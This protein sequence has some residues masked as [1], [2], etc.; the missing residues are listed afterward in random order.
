VGLELDEKNVQVSAVE[1]PLERFGAALIADLESSQSAFEGGKIDKIA[2]REPFRPTPL[3][4]Q[5]AKLYFGRVR[6][7]CP[8]PL[9]FGQVYFKLLRFSPS[10]PAGLRVNPP[11]RNTS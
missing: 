4:P 7:G 11:E 10:N 1:D 8:Q 3:C 6:E 5:S 2:W 9:V